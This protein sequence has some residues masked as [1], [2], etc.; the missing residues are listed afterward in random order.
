MYLSEEK[1]RKELRDC[2]LV[3]RLNPLLVKKVVFEDQS[4]QERYN[5]KNLNKLKQL[6]LEQTMKKIESQA[7]NI[8]EQQENKT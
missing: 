2:T 4:F 8:K 5:A 3:L 7:K 6:Q 1:G